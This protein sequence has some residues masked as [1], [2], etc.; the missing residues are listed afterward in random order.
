[1][2]SFEPA[3]IYDSSTGAFTATGF[4]AV[5]ANAIFALHRPCSRTGGC[6]TPEQDPAQLYDPATGTFTLTAN[7]PTGYSAVALL[8]NGE[9]LFAGGEDIGRLSSAVL[10]D[11]LT[12]AFSSTGAMGWSRVWH[13]LTLLADDEVLAAGG[14][15]DSCSSNGCFFAGSLATAELYDPASGTFS[16]T[17]SMAQAR[18]EHTATLLNDGRVLLAGGVV[19]GGINV[20]YGGTASAELYT[21]TVLVP[22]PRLFSLSGDGEG[23]GA[24]WDSTTGLVPSPV[25]PAVAGEILSMYTSGLSEGNVI[26]PQVS[27]GGRLAQILYFGDAPGWPGFF[28]VNFYVPNGIAPGSAVP[29]RLTYLGRSSNEVSISV[30]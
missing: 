22:A 21:P 23:Q 20:F 7:M 18:E 30:Q 9:V 19:Y 27:I 15:T 25:M 28:Q 5:A 29:V 2:G 8:V 12:G 26:P 14:E 6:C 1:M 11:P 10:Y 13:T 17:G 4:I 3:E 24:I 16:P